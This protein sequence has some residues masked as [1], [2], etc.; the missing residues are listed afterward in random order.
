MHCLRRVRRDV[1][2]ELALRRGI[3]ELLP[4]QRHRVG[5]APSQEV[6]AVLGDRGRPLSHGSSTWCRRRLS[7]RIQVHA[8]GHHRHADGRVVGPPERVVPAWESKFGR[9]CDGVAIRR[10]RRAVGPVAASARW[11]GGSRRILSTRRRTAPQQRKV[12]YQ[13]VNR[14]VVCQISDRT[15][16]STDSLS[17]I[18]IYYR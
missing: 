7:T 5:R 14:Q 2:V 8:A 12:S 9:L 1:V 11:R 17:Q 18:Y 6:V 10:H 3:H 16:L 15:C 4:A 13:I